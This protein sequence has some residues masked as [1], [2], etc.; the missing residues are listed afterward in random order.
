LRP[1]SAENEAAQSHRP[2]VDHRANNQVDLVDD[3]LAKRIQPA[4]NADMLSQCCVSGR[5][6]V[7]AAALVAGFDQRRAE[8]RLGKIR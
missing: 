3:H 2:F 1:S 8:N 6:A 4:A 7:S 5:A